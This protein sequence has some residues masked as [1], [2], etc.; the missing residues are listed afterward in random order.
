MKNALFWNVTQRR[1]L[2][3][4]VS[5]ERIASIIGKARIGELRKTLK[6]AAKKYSLF[7][8]TLIMDVIHSFEKSVLTRAARSNIPECGI[9]LLLIHVASCKQGYGARGVLFNT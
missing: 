6:H 9:L 1:F 8:F 3:S 2:R 7:L 5:E 4:D